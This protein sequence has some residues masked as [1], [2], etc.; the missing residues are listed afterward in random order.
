MII[1]IIYIVIITLFLSLLAHTLY[2]MFS[3]KKYADNACKDYNGIL[4]FNATKVICKDQSIW[5]WD[6]DCFYC[7]KSQSK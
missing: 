6:E 7:I 3:H 1:K 4:V 2:D 5:H